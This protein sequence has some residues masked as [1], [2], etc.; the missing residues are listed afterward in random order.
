M[1]GKIYLRIVLNRGNDFR[2][3]YKDA[4]DDLRSKI[5]APVLCCTAT[6]TEKVLSD[7][8]ESVHVQQCDLTTVAVVPDR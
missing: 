3:K 7:V 6:C 4:L 1:G 8:L 2:P 5:R